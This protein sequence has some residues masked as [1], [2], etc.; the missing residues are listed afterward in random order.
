MIFFSN[1]FSNKVKR[2]ESEASDVFIL[3]GDLR[4]LRI[5][6]EIVIVNSKN[7]ISVRFKDVFPA[8]PARAVYQIM[9][10]LNMKIF[11]LI[12]LFSFQSKYRM[13]KD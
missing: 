3:P 12:M 1:L 9:K 2:L 10:K 5:N 13:L 4:A 11:F 8:N 7:R 6:G